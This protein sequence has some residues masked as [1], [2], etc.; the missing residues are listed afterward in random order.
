MENDD[1]VVVRF[2]RMTT[3]THE[4]AR[5]FL[6]SAEWQLEPAVQL[7]LGSDDGGQ[8]GGT[9]TNFAVCNLEGDENVSVSESELL[10]PGIQM[11]RSA[12]TGARNPVSSAAPPELPQR[13]GSLDNRQTKPKGMEEVNGKRSASSRGFVTTLGDLKDQ[14]DSDSDSE[15]QEYYTGGE[16]SNSG[17][18]VQDPGKKHSHRD[19]EPVLERVRKLGENDAAEPRCA[20]AP[21][22][23]RFFSG[24]SH[25]LSG[26]TRQLEPAAVD[27]PGVQISPEP[28]V[29]DVQF[30]SNGIAVNADP[31]RRLDD[32]S[33]SPS[34]ES[35]NRSECPSELEPSDRG[36]PVHVNLERR[37]TSKPKYVPF[38]GAGHTI[39]SS[40]PV[41]SANDVSHLTGAADASPQHSRS[42]IV[43]EDKPA[44]SLQLR[45][46]DGT[47]MVVRFNNDHTVA[48]VRSF[49]DAAR[50][51]SSEN[52][53]LQ[54]VGFPPEKL[55]NLAQTIE[56]AGLR[57]AVIIQKR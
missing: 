34:L 49:I 26:Q 27:R 43:D 25:T 24:P 12:L 55:T 37:A 32:P 46:L 50:P 30:W 3:A 7:F 4:Q 40:T 36:I 52:Y 11:P 31:L 47:R 21:L 18:V 35:I 19:V 14:N 48:D 33:N 44:S 39:G 2:C 15:G 54:T 41:A 23:N 5:F 17:M 1:D 51:G 42:L 53:L 45:L 56:A 8:A 22:R 13:V 6:E 57:N 38:Q 29:K 16:K 28:I 20:A 9:A 10:A